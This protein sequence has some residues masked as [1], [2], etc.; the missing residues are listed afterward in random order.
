M[1]CKAV[2]HQETGHHHK[3]RQ[4]QQELGVLAG[5]LAGLEEV[6][7]SVGGEGPVVVLAGAVDAGKGLFMV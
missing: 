1:T 4:K 2:W 3:G 5:G 7:A 6:L